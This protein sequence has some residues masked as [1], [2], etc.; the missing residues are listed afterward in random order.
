M[1]DLKE[2]RSKGKPADVRAKSPHI[3]YSYPTAN[4]EEHKVK[5]MLF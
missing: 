4:I 1:E 3:I 5:D 2:M